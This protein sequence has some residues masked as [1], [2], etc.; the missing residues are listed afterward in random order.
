MRPPISHC[1]RKWPLI[2][3]AAFLL[4]V[5]GWTFAF[6]EIRAGVIG[7]ANSAMARYP[8]DRVEALSA[9]VDC[10]YCSLSDRNH[11]IWALGQLRDARALPVLERHYTGGPC[12]H[13]VTYASPNCRRRSRRSGCIRWCGSATETYRSCD[14]RT[15]SVRFLPPGSGWN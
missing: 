14:P 8:G 5:F 4:L 12:N 13:S 3:A 15:S 2:T 10:D 11:A 7:V 9:L 6:A 1:C